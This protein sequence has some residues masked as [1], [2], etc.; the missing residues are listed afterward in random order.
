MIPS[1]ALPGLFVLLAGVTLSAFVQARTADNGVVPASA[2]DD[3]I[4]V[5]RDIPYDHV[6]GVDPKLLSLDIYT[7]KRA[8]AA[9]PDPEPVVVYIHGG[10]WKI[11]DKANPD[12][13]SHKA[14]TFVSSGFVYVAINYRLSPAVHHPT[15]A[16]DVAKALA[17]VA[18]NI[19]RYSG[20]PERIYAMGHSAG[21]HLAALVATDES[22]L[23]REGHSLKTI[24][25]DILLDVGAY[26]IPWVMD[27][28]KEERGRE[29]FLS[30]FGNDP[31]V[32]G[33]ASPIYHV[34]AGKDIPPMRRRIE[35][36]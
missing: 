3:N 14:V 15:H 11:G 18:D 10:G 36:N 33:D 8:A 22:Y 32:W 28:L 4:T 31:K 30:A 7:P 26:D 16:Q 5:Y 12:S 6:A 19:G 21:A 2:F 25:G 29:L 9:S 35:A 34:A 1:G 20:D 23:K 13:G 24:K 27:H 17:W